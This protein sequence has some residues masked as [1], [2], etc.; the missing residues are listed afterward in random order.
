MLAMIGMASMQQ[1]SARSSAL[2]LTAQTNKAYSY[3][4]NK[5]NEKQAKDAI[6]KILASQ[7][8]KKSLGNMLSKQWRVIPE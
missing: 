3:I 8:N 2:S 5:S 6:K 1:L 4:C 7:S